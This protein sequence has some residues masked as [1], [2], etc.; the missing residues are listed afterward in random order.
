V[1]WLI[2]GGIAVFTVL[3]FA[4]A[5]L[6]SQ[7][8]GIVHGTP[9]QAALEER[10]RQSSLRFERLLGYHPFNQGLWFAMVRHGAMPAQAQTKQRALRV[11][12]GLLVLS[13]ATTFVA[14][15]AIVFMTWASN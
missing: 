11:I 1:L 8:M 12:V 5:I 9:A 14:M 6:A 7:I 10:C 3:N 15:L 13:F 2:G 4:A